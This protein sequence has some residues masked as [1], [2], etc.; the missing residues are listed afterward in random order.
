MPPSHRQARRTTTTC[1]KHRTAIELLATAAARFAQTGLAAPDSR[2]ESWCR[3]VTEIHTQRRTFAAHWRRH[4]AQALAD[5]GPLWVVLG[6][7]TAQGLGP[8]D[9]WH[10]YVG[11]TLTELHRR[12]GFHWRVLN[13]SR[14]GAL[15]RDV[16]NEQLPRLAEL[17]TTPQLITCGIGAN[18]ILHAPPPRLRAD[19]RAL[20][21]AVPDGT[22]IL[23]LPL[24]TG[25]WG[26]VGR[27]S[28][29]YVRQTNH[30]IHAAA[31]QRGLPIA[32]VSTHFI[33][34]WN[35]KFSPDRFHP[36]QIGYTSWAEALLRAIPPTS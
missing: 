1:G 23:D 16:L 11:Q 9:P 4:N 30:V 17:P 5:S 24:P 19:L 12:S 25:F 15:T 6:D 32:E 36:S 8:P 21:H 34:P 18:D 13:L 35:D 31:R 10:G 2:L 28:T 22:I 7:S 3:G 20:I 29:T 26:I 33:P 27:L 14:S